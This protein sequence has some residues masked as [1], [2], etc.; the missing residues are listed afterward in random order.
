MFGGPCRAAILCGAAVVTIADGRRLRRKR[1]VWQPHVQH[2]QQYAVQRAFQ[3]PTVQ[4]NTII[5]RRA[6]IIC[7]FF[8]KSKTPA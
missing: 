2:M 5:Q 4:Q 8:S 3:H 7:A 6:L 1:H